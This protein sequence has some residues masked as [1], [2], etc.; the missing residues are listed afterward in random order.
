M[1]EPKVD[2]ETRLEQLEQQNSL[3]MTM[4]QGFAGQQQA[5]AAD[6]EPQIVNNGWRPLYNPKRK[7]PDNR[8]WQ[9]GHPKKWD[10]DKGYKVGYNTFHVEDG[11]WEWGYED[12]E[13]G[14]IKW[15]GKLIGEKPPG[16]PKDPPVPIEQ[17]REQ[18]LVSAS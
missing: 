9:P 18:M 6:K 17:L 2:L 12:P 13:T 3:L 10:P 7:N 15:S 14:K 1:P 8:D 5:Q 16:P 4:L 11:M